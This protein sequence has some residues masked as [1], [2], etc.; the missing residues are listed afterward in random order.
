MELDGAEGDRMLLKLVNKPDKRGTAGF[1]TGFGWF[2]LMM[3]LMLSAGCASGDDRAKGERGAAEAEPIELVVAAAASLTESMTEAGTLFET[4]FPGVKLIYHFGSS[5]TLQRQIEQGAPADLFFPAG[6]KHVEALIENRLVDPANRRRLLLNELVVV[7]RKEEAKTWSK[8]GD[9][10]GPDVKT[11]AIGIPDTVPAGEYA[12]EALT[13]LS[14][15]DRLQNKL[16]Q[17]KDVRQVLTYVETGNADAGFVYRTDAL[18][19]PKVKQAFAVDRNAYSPVVYSAAIVKST[20]HPAE[21]ARLL[22]FLQSKEALDVF[23]KR[24]FSA[25]EPGGPGAGR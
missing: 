22:E 7:V 13:S 14:L 25:A 9:L 16:V 17:G 8:P 15:W 5:G 12:K 19:S 2:P 11:V 3:M 18:A 6:D 23:I 24:G 21:S 1:F 4:S 10:A 20:K